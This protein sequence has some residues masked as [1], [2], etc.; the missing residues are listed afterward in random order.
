M[1]NAHASQGKINKLKLPESLKVHEI[2]LARKDEFADTTLRVATERIAK[3]VP[4]KLTAKNVWTLARAIGLEFKRAKKGRR[5]GR[6]KDSRA[7]RIRELQQRVGALED[8]VAALS[9]ELDSVSK[10]Y[11]ALFANH[12][13]HEQHLTR[14]RARLDQLVKDLGGVSSPSAVDGTLFPTV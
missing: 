1:G 8:K 9:A 4:F 13:E 6:C 7:A 12:S 14:T 3:E 2:L 10:H 5:P 11:S